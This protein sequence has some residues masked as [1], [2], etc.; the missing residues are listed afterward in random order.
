MNKVIKENWFLVP[1]V[2]VVSAFFFLFLKNK[3]STT[4]INKVETKNI[5]VN[6]L[7]KGDHNIYENSYYG[8]SIAYPTGWSRSAPSG[9]ND[10]VVFYAGDSSVDMRVFASSNSGNLFESN[11]LVLDNG[12]IA[13][14]IEA[15][16]QGNKLL[17]VY[18]IKNDIK[19]EFYA[20]AQPGYYE[21][22]KE[23]L[24]QVARSLEIK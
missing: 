10:G 6:P 17:R 16:V 9:N 19:Y 23:L 24:L 12:N 7:V 5:Q 14:I 13:T 2:I 4:P 21:K 11:T 20:E 18:F 15:D 3:N 8:F 1:I 22:N